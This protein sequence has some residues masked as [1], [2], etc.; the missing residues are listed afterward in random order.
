MRPRKDDQIHKCPTLLGRGSQAGVP[1]LAAR[2]AKGL[3]SRR[4]V[5]RARPPGRRMPRRRKSRCMDT[6]PHSRTWR[7]AGR[8]QFPSGNLWLQTTVT[9]GPR[10]ALASRDKY[11]LDGRAALLGYGGESLTATTY[12]APATAASSGTRL[13]RAAESTPQMQPKPDQA[14]SGLSLTSSHGRR[15]VGLQM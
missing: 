3:L 6:S 5:W 13:Q 8:N 11:A 15:T 2:R 12:I 4:C 10:A 1:L 7:V 14:Q 9:Q